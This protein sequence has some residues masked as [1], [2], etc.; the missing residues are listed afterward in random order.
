[1]SSPSPSEAVA[2]ARTAQ[3]RWA[4]LPVRT[5][6]QHLIRFRKALIADADELGRL[7]SRESGK[8]AHETILHEL[9]CLSDNLT[10][11]ARNAPRAF[12]ERRLPLHLLKHR[13]SRIQYLPRR[14]TA[15]ISPFN[16][17]L[18]IPLSDAGAALLAGSAVVAKPSELTA[19]CLTRASAQWKSAGL[20][21]DLLQVLP[22][23]GRAGSELIASG[24]DQVLFTGG[25]VA[26]RQV[27]TACAERLI[28]S[29]LEL[30][31][32][33]PAIVCADADLDLAAR[34]IVF[35]ACCN[36][37]QSCVS[38][39]R[40]YAHRNIVD[41]LVARLTELTSRLSVGP[42]QGCHDIGSLVQPGQVERLE[43]MVA[44]A[45]SDGAQLLTGG[46]RIELSGQFFAPTVLA[47]CSHQM[48]VM[49]QE[50]FG[51]VIPVMTVQ[52]DEQAV[53]LANDSP[54][55]LAGY[56]FTGSQTRGRALASALEVGCVNV[57]DTI[58]QYATMEAPFG[59]VKAS[60]WGRIH[61]L[62]ALRGLADVKHVSTAR[63]RGIDARWLWSPYSEAKLKWLQR[64]MR[65]MFG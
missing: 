36:A 1:M 3:P 8:P 38:V 61:G 48:A 7:V 63:I 13:V 42:P 11:M 10:W 32:N 41:S 29:V 53:A 18:L 47:N 9:M 56:V 58:F 26:G 27:A 39:E 21:P 51:P 60:G 24:V 45:V 40:V 19:G 35:G 50:C 5:R 12:R 54:V 6:A 30:G 20:D 16:F 52:D 59:G 2:R 44:A 49:Q 34:A 15:V 37:G 57:N 65:W 4:R 64:L 14:V 43:R 17:P 25:T 33:A 23:D 31:G 28:P 46:H 62:D 22:G 55:G